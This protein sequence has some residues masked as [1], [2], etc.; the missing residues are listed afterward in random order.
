[1]VATSTIIS[2]FVSFL[3]S[4]GTPVALF[5]VAK[6]KWNIS[7]KVVLFGM[8]TFFVFA[9]VLEGLAHTYFLVG[10][11]TTRTW[12]QNPWLFMLYGGFMAGIFEESGRYIVMKYALK[13]YR[14]WKDGF[15]FGIGHGG[16]EAFLLVGLNSIVMIVFSFMINNGLFDRMLEMD[17]ALAPVKEQLIEGSS[18]LVLLGGIERISAIAIHIGLS[19]LVIYSLKSKNIMYFLLAILLHAILDFPAA[20]YQAG[21]IENIYIVEMMI[22]LIAAISI[23]WIVKS[24]RL[25]QTTEAS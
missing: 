16:I 3:I 12:L 5:I 15:A 23:V 8:L 21:V 24:K 6:K 11:E 2:M 4:V 19:I 13:T 9:N 7:I 10:N 17:A 1:M 18:L 14:K 25:F 22:A 20:L